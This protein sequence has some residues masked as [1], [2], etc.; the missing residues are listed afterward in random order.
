MASIFCSFFSFWGF[1]SQ[2]K[3]HHNVELWVNISKYNELT[4]WSAHVNDKGHILITSRI[5]KMKIITEKYNFAFKWIFMHRLHL[6]TNGCIKKLIENYFS[7]L[8]RKGYQ[9]QLISKIE[10]SFRILMFLDLCIEWT[11]RAERR[12][13]HKTQKC[14]VRHSRI[15]WTKMR[16]SIESLWWW[17]K[18]SCSNSWWTI[19]IFILHPNNI[20]VFNKKRKNMSKTYSKNCVDSYA[21]NTWFIKLFFFLLILK[22]HS[23][24][25]VCSEFKT[26][27]CKWLRCLK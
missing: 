14:P 17:C 2:V 15:H 23:I 25:D 19:R 6:R 7:M 20:F 3:C 16:W 11:T 9:N 4:N 1:L 5:L 10:L 21:I 22:E 18:L 24:L 13:E 8:I 27:G 12:N 26:F